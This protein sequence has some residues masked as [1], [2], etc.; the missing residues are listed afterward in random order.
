[1]DFQNGSWKCVHWIPQP[2]SL[3]M[4]CAHLYT[5]HTSCAAPESFVQFDN[6][7]LVDEGIEDPNITMNGPSSAPQQNTI[8]MA[9]HWR[10]DYFNGP[11][12]NACLVALWFLGDPDQYCW[13]TLYFCDFSWGGGGGGG[14]WTPCPPPSGSAHA[15][16]IMCKLHGKWNWCWPA[17]TILVL[18][19]LSSNKGSG[20]CICTL[21]RARKHKVWL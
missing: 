18:I 14:G 17:Y 15:L 10:A 9:F 20:D 3:L 12:L 4:K 7:F 19:A 1:M 13:E 11:Q 6:F 5:V 21:P 16:A 2:A 8:K